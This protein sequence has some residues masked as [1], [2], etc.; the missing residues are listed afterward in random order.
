MTGVEGRLY[1]CIQNKHF[2]IEIISKGVIYKLTGVKGSPSAAYSLPLIIYT[3]NA[4][5]SVSLNSFIIFAVYNYK[6]KLVRPLK[7]KL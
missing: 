5:E 3:S 1:T 2:K 7:I 6:Q 4:S